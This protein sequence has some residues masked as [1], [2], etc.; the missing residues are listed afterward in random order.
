MTTAADITTANT[1]IAAVTDAATAKTALEAV[2]VVLSDLNTAIGALTTT[3][4]DLTAKIDVATN[5]KPADP[6][7]DGTEI[8]TD[9]P[10]SDPT[11]LVP[12]PGPTSGIIYSAVAITTA[13]VP[14]GTHSVAYSQQLAATGGVGSLTWSLNASTPLPSGL[15]LS[16]AGLL[17]G[18]PGADT[19]GAYSFIVTAKDT[20]GNS[21]SRRYSLTIA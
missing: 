13:S 2:S 14:N 9:T 20:Q 19:A 3:L 17:A 10:S 21:V 4:N 12:L 18:T 8:V 15:T 5:I 7:Q 16:S 1:A 6:Y 11:A